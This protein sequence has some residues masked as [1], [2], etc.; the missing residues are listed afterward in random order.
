M[1]LF[2]QR[3]LKAAYLFAESGGQ[4]LL[5]LRKPEFNPPVGRIIDHNYERLYSTVRRLG[6]KAIIADRIDQPGQSV[7]IRGRQLNRAIAECQTPEL[8]L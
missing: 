2:E 7:E 3:D 8:A 5:M 4:A 1:R 6:F